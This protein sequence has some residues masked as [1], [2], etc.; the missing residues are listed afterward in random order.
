MRILQ[1]TSAWRLSV[2]CS[3][4][5]NTIYTFRQ[6]AVPKVS[7]FWNSCIVHVNNSSVV[8]S[9]W[10][11]ARPFERK[12]SPKREL[13]VPLLILRYLDQTHRFLLRPLP[14]CPPPLLVCGRNLQFLRFWP[15]FL[16]QEAIKR[17]RRQSAKGFRSFKSQAAADF[18][19]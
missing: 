5:T 18:Y 4:F 3:A 12:N 11:A 2:F 7:R 9:E 14:L 19:W 10:F 15:K 17:Y 8:D 13:R 6:F 16:N 1:W